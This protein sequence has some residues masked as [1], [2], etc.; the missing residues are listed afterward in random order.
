M[1]GEPGL[2]SGFVLR[3]V[4]F[5]MVGA[6]VIASILASAALMG[7]PAAFADGDPAS[8]VLSNYSAFVPPDANI[9]FQTEAR[10]KALLKAGAAVG[11][12]IRVA[13]INSSADLGTVT[14]LWEDP[15]D[16]SEY[17]WTEI[18]TC[19]CQV[20]V[21]MPNGFGLWGPSHGPHAIGAAEHAVL[22]PSPGS[23]PKLAAAALSAV[24]LLASAAGHPIPKADIHVQSVSIKAAKTPVAGWIAL[25][26]GVLLIAGCWRAS[27]KAR[28]L[29]LPRRAH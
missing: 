10:L 3:S 8:D 2:H 13:L 23:G 25:I 18:S 26:V 11:F 24:P 15:G 16:Y 14:S 17:L 9:S 27:V 12:P 21:V 4:R 20:L 5:A 29:N 22:A 19:G 28:P 1:A 7:A 6:A